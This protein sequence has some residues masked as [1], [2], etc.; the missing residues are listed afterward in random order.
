[1]ETVECSVCGAE[2]GLGPAGLG[3]KQHSAMHRREFRE[4]TGR[5]EAD[6]AEVREFFQRDGRQ[7]TLDEALTADEQRALLEYR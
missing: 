1:M 5:Q 2:V 4:L 7:P 3:I 6:Y